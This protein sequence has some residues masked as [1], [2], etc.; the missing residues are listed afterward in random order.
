MYAKLLGRILSERI[1]RYN[2]DLVI[3]RDYFW[4]TCLKVKIP[5]IYIGDTT[6]RFFKENLRI[7][8]AKFENVADN[9]EKKMIDNSDCI[10]FS[11]DWARHSAVNDY[12]CIEDKIHI[13]EFGANI[14]H[15]ERYQAEI[16]TNVCNLVFIGR[17]WEK[18]EVIRHWEHIEN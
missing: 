1:N 2:Y 9:L 13:V 14:P 3:V 8:S 11:S 5:I 7:P 12:N 6:F 16:D 17:N 10:I 18:N 15:P 4:G